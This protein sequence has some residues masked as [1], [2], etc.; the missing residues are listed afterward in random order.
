MFFSIQYNMHKTQALYENLRLNGGR[1]KMEDFVSGLN[2]A[3]YFLY[4]YR[5]KKTYVLALL[6]NDIRRTS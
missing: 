3:Q 2:C 4:L 5:K 6:Y 1:E